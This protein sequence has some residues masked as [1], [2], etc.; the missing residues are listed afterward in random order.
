MV[1]LKYVSVGSFVVVRNLGPLVTLGFEVAFHQPNGL[2][3]DAVTVGATG[4]LAFGVL[5]YESHDLTF[6]GVGLF[7]LVLNLLSACMER[8]AQRHLLAIK[9]VDCSTPALMVLNNGIGAALAV[10]LLHA[11]A[12]HEWHDMKRAVYHVRGAGLAVGLSAVVGCGISYAGL[13]L[14]RLVTATSFMVLGSLTKLV[15]I[16]W[17]ILY[18]RDAHSPFAL[19]G[20]ALAIGGGFVYARRMAKRTR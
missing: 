16:A 17:G 2:K 7:F 13:W 1:A 19:L 9:Q 12:P 6:S 4:A 3:C 15:V 11:F 10:V 5:L 14:Q 8:L 20:V 18:M